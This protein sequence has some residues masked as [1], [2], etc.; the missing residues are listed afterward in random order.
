MGEKC[1]ICIGMTLL[2]LFLPYGLTMLMTG[3]DKQQ[4]TIRDSGIIVE[5]EI[6]GELKT[7]DLE[8]YMIGVLLAE[9]PY[10]Y[11]LAVY[12][13]QAVITRTNAR[14]LHKAGT[15]LLAQDLKV[16][17][18]TEEGMIKQLGQTRYEEQLKKVKTA[19]GNTYGMV[20]TYKGNY[21][22]A[23]YHN[24]SMGQTAS[25]LDVY[26]KDIPYLTSVDSSA[27][28]E[29]KDYMQTLTFTYEQLVAL[30]GD[31]YGLTPENFLA[32]VAIS[33][34]SKAG[35]V[36][37][38]K[39]GTGNITGEEF[40]Q[41]LS[42]NSTYFYMESQENQLKIVCLGKGHGM[43]LSLYGANQMA[44]QGKGVRELL[45]YYYQG[46]SVEVIGE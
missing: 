44:K 39:L 21:I 42:L 4:G 29:A 24:V 2:M 41:L 22:D 37:M 8:Q 33:E 9:L 6:A 35:Y 25:A 46:A 27:D 7:A 1:I 14:K 5:Y 11:E 10:D 20:L 16:S 12:E 3:Y 38:V 31:Q 13:A 34:K 45:T 36:K 30:L 40:K 43:G 23:L 18:A 19:I 26:G 32:E 17:Y 28:V 15:N